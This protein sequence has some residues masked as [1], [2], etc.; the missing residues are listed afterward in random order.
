MPSNDIAVK[1]EAER[2]HLLYQ[3]NLPGVIAL[4]IYSFAYAYVSQ[5]ILSPMLLWVWLGILTASAVLRVIA[6]FI[7]RKRRSRI[8]ELGE[9]KPWMI[10]IHVMLFISGAGWGVIGWMFVDSPSPAHQIFTALTIVFMAAGAIVC[11]AISKWAIYLV[12]VPAM[13]PWAV[14]LLMSPD[15]GHK[16]M[17]ALAGI[18]VLLGFRVGATLHRY[19]EDSLNL[20]IE[21]ARLAH[22]LKQE[23]QVKDLAE[24]ALRLALASSDAMSW[25]WN[26]E[27]DVFTCT[28]DLRRSL[29][30]EG[31]RFSGSLDEFIQL[32]YPQDQEKFRTIMFRLALK[33]GDLDT[34]HR[35]D[36]PDGSIHDLAF[37]GKSEPDERGRAKT[38]TGIAWDIT[39]KRSQE[40]LQQERD[41]HEAANKAKSAFLANASHEIRT[42][43]AAINGY[44]EAVLQSPDLTPGMRADLE[45]ISRNGKYLTSLVNDFLDL[46]RIESGRF[47]VQKSL[48]PPKQ[49]IEE[50][51]AILRSMID[52]KH[53][54]VQVS[55][56]TPL[57]NLIET[58]PVRF[59]QIMVNLLSNATKFTN[60]GGIQVKVSHATLPNREGRLSIRV[61]DT[62]IGMDA[63]IQS[64]L[65]EPFSRSE[66]GEVQR[67]SGSGLGLPLSRHLARKLGGDVRLVESAIG[68]GSEFEFFI[69]TGPVSRSQYPPSRDKVSG[70]QRLKGVKV[71]V[72]DDAEELRILMRRLLEKQGANV[73]TAENGLEGVD[74]A[75]HGNFDLVLMDI[76]MP[77]MDGVEATSALRQ[78]GF[79]APIVA[80]TAHASLEDRKRCLDAGCNEYLSKPIEGAHLIQSISSILSKDSASSVVL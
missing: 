30:I 62:G 39:A 38:L 40:K 47:D 52:S 75:L 58:D 4:L 25:E 68:V 19:M 54:N 1:L 64:H 43:L 37:R 53:L 17:G 56:E 33:G 10:F 79:K 24:E 74:Q 71:L 27:T 36:W 77:V 18:Y 42:P 45:A 57:P 32:I 76:K 11:Y 66:A 72:V 14:S 22:S 35:V 67:I 41:I 29:G 2:V 31:K 34:D 65:F 55:Y 28:G 5:G 44:V 7:W 50:A 15:P 46:S 60:S 3:Q 9:L 51:I 59:R 23:I 6:Y 63:E 12:I 49:E 8:R 26:V 13:V 20:N 80:I 21:N 61:T 70:P 16:F 48:V 69:A 73:T 78:G